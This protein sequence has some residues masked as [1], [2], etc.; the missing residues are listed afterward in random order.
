MLTQRQRPQLALASAD[1]DS[2]R[3]HLSVAFPNGDT[4][5]SPV[6]LGESVQTVIWGRPVPGRVVVGPWSDALSRFCGGPVRLVKTDDAGLSYDEYPISVLSQ[7]S[8]DLLDSITD[9]FKDLGA[10]RFRPNLLIDGCSPHEEDTWLGATVS[11]GPELRLRIV[12]PDPRCAVTTVN[13]ETG[14]RDFDTPR[15]LLTYRP[16]RGAPY[17]GMYAIVETPGNLSIGDAVQLITS[18]AD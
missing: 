2:A 10:R 14:K 13:P 5:S 8:L 9:G 18:A 17:F 6:E 4:S 3:E 15:L 7:A 1:Y 12:A 16:S 11:V